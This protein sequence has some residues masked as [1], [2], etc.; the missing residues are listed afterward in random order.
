MNIE[1]RQ[2]FGLGNKVQIYNPRFSIFSIQHIR[3]NQIAALV[4]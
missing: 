2:Y 3:Y 4:Q 1:K